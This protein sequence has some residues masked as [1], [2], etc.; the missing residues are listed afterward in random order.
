MNEHLVTI[1][2]VSG[3]QSLFANESLPQNMSTALEKTATFECELGTLNP[4]ISMKNSF[5]S[6]A[7]F[8]KMIMLQRMVLS[9]CWC[10]ANIVQLNSLVII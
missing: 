10:G 3:K 6:I 2:F 8:W 5:L 4:D 1:A 7:N 9:Q